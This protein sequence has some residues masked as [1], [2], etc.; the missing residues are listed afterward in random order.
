MQNDVEG[1]LGIHTKD[2][3][4]SVRELL[5]ESAAAEQIS[6]DLH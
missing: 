1:L 5:Q 6:R 2:I 3:R 4:V